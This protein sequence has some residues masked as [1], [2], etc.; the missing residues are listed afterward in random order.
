MSFNYYQISRFKNSDALNGRQWTNIS[1][2]IEKFEIK[3]IDRYL[4]VEND[5]IDFLRMFYI[6]LSTRPQEE[7][8]MSFLGFNME[9][10]D[11]EGI[12]SEFFYGLN[13]VEERLQKL[14]KLNV[15]YIS[16]DDLNFLLTCW[17]RRLCSLWLFETGTGSYLKASDEDFTFSLMLHDNWKLSDIFRPEENVY[18][19]K[20]L[21][22]NL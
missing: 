17:V 10:D 15:N 5:F 22:S 16:E 4:A 3:D 13:N 2:F 14:V 21:D 7:Y 12:E 8:G 18:F 1:N 19:H 9:L 6:D 11:L 20:S